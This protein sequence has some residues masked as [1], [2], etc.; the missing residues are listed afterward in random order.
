MEQKISQFLDGIKFSSSDRFDLVMAIRALFQNASSEF[1][2][3]IKYGG[4]TYSI[5]NELVSGI[6]SYKQHVS[7][8]F[9]KGS[10]FPDPK[11]VLEGGGKHRRHIKIRALNDIEKRTVD[12][13]IQEAIKAAAR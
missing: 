9:G 11:D 10:E 6:F 13:Y 3:G 5:K 4:L 8:E 7:I 1:V 2:E 12:F